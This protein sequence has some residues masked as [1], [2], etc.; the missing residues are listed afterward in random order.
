MRIWSGPGVVLHFALLRAASSSPMVKGE[1]AD[2][3]FGS[4][5]GAQQR[6]KG[7]RRSSAADGYPRS[8]SA[9]PGTDGSDMR[10]AGCSGRLL[11]EHGFGP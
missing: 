6:W 3:V 2:I 11:R 8:R 5:G 10:T 1:S 7:G 4:L 9:A